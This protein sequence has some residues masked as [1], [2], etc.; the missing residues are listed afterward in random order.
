M[1]SKKV[2]ESIANVL[3]RAMVD[4]GHGFTGT[5]DASYVIDQLGNMFQRDNSRF[6]P[7]KFREA[8]LTG[9]HI[10]RSIKG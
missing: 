1:M 4:T 5:L 2:Y 3:N 9:A 10:R 8:C 7:G 6:N